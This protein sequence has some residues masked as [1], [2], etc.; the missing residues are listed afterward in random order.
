MVSANII[1]RLKKRGIER[2]LMQPEEVQRLA[3]YRA[4]STVPIATRGITREPMGAEHA[5]F[6]GG[7][8]AF[9][10][11]VQKHG[12]KQYSTEDLKNV[13]AAYDE[14]VE[15]VDDLFHQLR[16]QELVSGTIIRNI[17]QNSMNLLRS[18]IDLYVS[19]CLSPTADCYPSKHSMQ[20]SM[21]AMSIGA[22]L[23][24]MPEVL[25]DLGI[26]CLMH[27]AGMLQIDK[28][29]YCTKKKLDHIDF[30]AITKHPS[31]SFDSVQ[32][33]SE[34]TTGARMVVYQMHERL[35]GSGY[36]RG[37]QGN[38]IH[39]LSKIA[40]VADVF[41]A[42]VSPRP[43]RQGKLPFQALREIIEDTRRGMFDPEIVRALLQTISLFPI[44]S[45]VEMSDG[46]QGKVLRANP[47]HP[48]RPIVE[49]AGVRSA[50]GQP[51][52]VDLSQEDG[53]RI[54]RPLKSF[55]VVEAN[56]ADSVSETAEDGNF[57]VPDLTP[58]GTPSS[59]NKL[60]AEEDFWE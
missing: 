50:D 47:D 15:Q 24:L 34:V 3:A 2:V 8:K 57:E 36:P 16:A 43:H 44:G 56:G 32:G 10:N 29:L 35:N 7:S 41:V 48:D 18:D 23:G 13:E 40:S 51:R 21:L 26:G 46:R 45:Y 49:L 1:K 30:L 33:I 58:A 22:T 39:F 6:F 28:R 60:V 55:G 11:Q 14:S 37:S 38:R 42:L 20:S 25:Y 53:L 27:D 19:K 5:D 17:A 31:L 54:V 4:S 12:V 52:L 9:V 59:E